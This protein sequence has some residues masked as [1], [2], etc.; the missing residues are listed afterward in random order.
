MSTTKMIIAITVVQLLLG[1]PGVCYTACQF[2]GVT[3]VLPKAVR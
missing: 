1:P 3:Q 2:A